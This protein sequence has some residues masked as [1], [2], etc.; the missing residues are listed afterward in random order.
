MRE[1]LLHF[2][3][4]YKK[5]QLK[6]L[7]TSE[8]EAI[9]I[10]DVGRHNHLAGPD[11]FNARVKIDGQLWGGNVEIHLKSSDWYVHGHEKDTNYHNVIL[12][13]VWEDDVGVFRKDGTLLPTLELGNYISGNVLEAYQRL[14]DKKGINFINCEKDIRD[15]DSFLLQNWLERLYFERLERKSGLVMEL[16]AQS[17]NDWE[18]VLFVLLLKSFG[19]NINGDPFLSIG[20]AMHFSTVRKVQHN[21][22]QL[23]SILFGLAGFLDD[24]TIVDEYHIDLRKE[25]R[26]LQNKFGLENTSVRQ[27][28]FFKLR[29]PNFPTIRLSQAANL[30]G[31][32]QNLF[33][34]LMEAS[35]LEQIY[36]VFDI[37]AS[38]Y[39]DTH[40][41]FG[42]TSR[43]S[44]KKLTKKFIDLIIINTILPL[45]FCYARHTGVDVN[46][47]IVRIISLL[48]REQNSVVDNFE[49]HGVKMS[50]AMDSQAVLQLYN[51]YCSK[52]KCLQC[53]VGTSLLNRNG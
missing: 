22:L 3:W 15:I 32:H 42:K 46:E 48:K 39:W 50:N 35:D 27:P 31:K 28:E 10:M 4:K 19:S 11:F 53:A 24:D 51:E 43:K 26:Y 14:F 9:S 30:Y 16:L 21:A 25:Y 36:T 38:T 6:D 37:S 41:T 45:K 8:N 49:A 52:N 18:K 12:H 33:S 7:S 2:I 47:E 23:E 44:V 40:F 34:K 5:L 17:K 13:V 1:D 20:Q 29:P